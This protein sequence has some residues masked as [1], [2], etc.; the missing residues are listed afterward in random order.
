[1]R[2]LS[3]LVTVLLA[4]EADNIVQK[5]TLKE[6]EFDGIA[7][8][9]HIIQKSGAVELSA[10]SPL[11]RIEIVLYKEGKK[12]PD[13]L[14]SAGVLAG[15]S[16]RENDRIRFALNVVDMDYLTLGDGK[17]E[18]CR[19]LMKLGIGGVTGS[20]HMTFRKRTATSAS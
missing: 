19:L 2:F 7:G 20:V 18:H 5:I 17:K 16:Q 11:A 1:M 4:A 3:L 14:A 12:L 8:A 15:P 10:D 9:L 13:L 6:P